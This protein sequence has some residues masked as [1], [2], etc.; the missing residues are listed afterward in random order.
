AKAR[1]FGDIEDP[2]SEVYK[3]IKERNGFVLFS[4]AGT[5]PGNHYLPRTETKM[6]VDEHLLKH[7]NPLFLE[8]LRRHHVGG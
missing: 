6:H 7:D 2:D 4:D 8:V 5:N 1:F 3:V